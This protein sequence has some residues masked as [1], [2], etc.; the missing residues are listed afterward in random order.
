VKAVADPIEPGFGS[1]DSH[2]HGPGERLHSMSFCSSVA[3]KLA[4][5]Y[6]VLMPVELV[7]GLRE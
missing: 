3:D 7:E 4:V 6:L 5:V 1:R 2:C